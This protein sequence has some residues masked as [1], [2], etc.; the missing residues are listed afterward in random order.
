MPYRI[1]HINTSAG[2]GGGERLLLEL[3]RYLHGAEFQ[4]DFI[5]PQHGVFCE[6]L[7]E[8]GL[9]YTVVDMTGKV[10]PISGMELYRI[11][12][13]GQPDIVHTYGARASWYARIPARMAGVPLVFCTVQNSLY[14]YPYPAWRRA[15]YMKLEG[16]TGGIVDQWIAVSS[17]LRYDMVRRYG[18]PSERVE[19]ILN[20]VSKEQ[21]A[22]RTPRPKV[23]RS[24]GLDEDSLALIEVA[25]MTDQKGH[26]FLLEAIRLLLPVFSKISCFLVGDGPN[27]ADL[28]RQAARLGISGQVHFLG[29][30]S[31]VPDLLHASDVAV[32]PSLSE[33][34][35]LAVLESMGVGCATVATRVNGT[36][37]IIT[38][39]VDGLLVPA[40]DVGAL[41]AAVREL[42]ASPEL[43]QGIA[44]RGRETVLRRFTAERMA[45]AVGELYHLRL[46]AR[47]AGGDT[48][49]G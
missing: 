34:L 37:E 33:G 38:D 14:D 17:A 12:R 8:A 1:T 4:F 40:A 39:R 19:V 22:V 18:I 47:G 10:R 11:F 20:G 31:D 32:L 27:R 30:R 7:E 46:A 15:L 49:R 5:L 29:F 9:P 24:L 3:A 35:P 2:V 23:R 41:A 21:I 44:A 28:E 25:R 42:A 43:R 13:R 16:L 26:R 45:S 36:A 48:R 6:R